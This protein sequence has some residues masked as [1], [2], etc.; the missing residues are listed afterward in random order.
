MFILA[1]R[2]PRSLAYS[3]EAAA[4]A[5]AGLRRFLFRRNSMRIFAIVYSLIISLI[6]KI[7]GLLELFLFIRL[8]LK[9]LNA[10]PKTLIVNLI[11]KW[12][13]TLVYPFKNI[14]PNTYWPEGYVIEIPTIAA[15]IGYAIAVFIIFQLLR[16]FSKERV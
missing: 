14:L 4:A 8:L 11:Y 16:L 5:K 2:I 7:F 9:F 15:M 6:R 3:A 1:A 13:D 10:N 12:S